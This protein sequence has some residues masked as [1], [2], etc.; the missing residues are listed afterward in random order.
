MLDHVVYDTSLVLSNKLTSLC[1]GIERIFQCLFLGLLSSCY[2]VQP[3]LRKPGVQCK[4]HYGP[5]QACCGFWIVD[6]Q[7][8]RGKKG[9]TSVILL[10]VENF[11]RCPIDF[12]SNDK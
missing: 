5:G 10:L 1:R 6:I 4:T 11:E 7:E 12:Q 9:H 2:V 8:R 3:S